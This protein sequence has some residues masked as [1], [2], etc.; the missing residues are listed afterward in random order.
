VPDR[1]GT[2]G[3]GLWLHGQARRRCW[4]FRAA[5][6]L[7]GD[8]RARPELPGWPDAAEAVHGSPDSPSGGAR[9]L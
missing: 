7:G 8:N 5:D 6:G 4:Q 3:R 9:A 1:V 2:L